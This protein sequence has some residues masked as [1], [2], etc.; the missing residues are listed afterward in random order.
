MKTIEKEDGIYYYNDNGELHREDGP[1]IKRKD[2]TEEW[3]RNGVR[4][5][6]LDGPQRKEIN[7]NKI[8]YIA[9]G[10]NSKKDDK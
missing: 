8:W 10:L 9:G 4:Y 2:G 1:A 6:R 3:Y 7:G 5:S